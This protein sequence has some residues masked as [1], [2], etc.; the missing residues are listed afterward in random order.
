MKRLAIAAL[1]AASVALIA[2][3]ANKFAAPRSVV[4]VVTILWKEDSTAEQQQAAIDGVKKMAADIPG[5]RSV[6]IKPL[7][8][9]G[10]GKPGKDGKPG[11]PYDSAFVIEFADQAAAE[12]YVDHP[13]HVEWNKTYLAIR[14]ESTSHQISN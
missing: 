12:R 10:R 13:A 6:W 4:H 2:M 3:A 7:K 14:E 1:V 9:Q 5:I 8:V 11:R